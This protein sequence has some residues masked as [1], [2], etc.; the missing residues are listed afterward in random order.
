MLKLVSVSKPLIAM[1]TATFGM[2]RLQMVNS[3]SLGLINV[4]AEH[5]GILSVTKIEP[6]L[7]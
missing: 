3:I 6:K 1:H 2:L 4:A 7:V 5:T